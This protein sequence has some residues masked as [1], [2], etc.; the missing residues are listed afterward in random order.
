MVDADQE[1]FLLFPWRLLS[2]E[3]AAEQRAAPRPPEKG[4]LSTGRGR[5]SGHSTFVNTLDGRKIWVSQNGRSVWGGLEGDLGD[6]V[7]PLPFCGYGREI[8]LNLP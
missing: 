5:Q 3:W 7:H 2:W 8:F 4:A 6:E 1:E